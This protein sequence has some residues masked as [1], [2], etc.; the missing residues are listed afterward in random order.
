MVYLKSSW[1]NVDAYK[2]VLFY[3]IV[4]VQTL[5]IIKQQGSCIFNNLEKHF[6]KRPR[7]MLCPTNFLS[8]I[9]ASRLSGSL[10]SRAPS[11]LFSPESKSGI[12][13]PSSIS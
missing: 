8:L 7:E 9:S 5:F 6:K 3:V 12:P 1:L 11:C 10:S 13:K 2:T 4:N